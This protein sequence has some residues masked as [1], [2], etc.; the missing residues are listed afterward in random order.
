MLQAME[1]VVMTAPHSKHASR[2]APPMPRQLALLMPKHLSL[3]HEGVCTLWLGCLHLAAHVITNKRQ[4][5]E[6]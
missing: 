5:G 1:A 4:Q 6:P 3:M 2:H